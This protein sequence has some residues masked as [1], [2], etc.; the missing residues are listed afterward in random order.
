MNFF[1]KYKLSILLSLCGIGCLVAYHAIGAYI[2]KDGV[3]IE[4]FGFLPLF[5]IFQLLALVVLTISF[6]RSR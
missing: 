4:S 1:H 6:F 5:W 2:N 3:L